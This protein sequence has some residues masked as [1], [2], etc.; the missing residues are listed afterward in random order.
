MP[1]NIDYDSGVGCL[2]CE[3]VDSAADIEAIVHI[4]DNFNNG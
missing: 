4:N 2:Y 1:C 3:A